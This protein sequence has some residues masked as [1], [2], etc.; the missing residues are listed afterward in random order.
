MTTETQPGAGP[1]R[2]FAALPLAFLALFLWLAATGSGTRIVR[3]P[4]GAESLGFTLSFRLDGLS[5]IFGTLISGIGVLVFIYGASYLA[6][7]RDIVRFFSWLSVF[8]VA[9]LGVVASENLIALF[10]FWELTSLSSWFLI[11]TDHERATAR[12]AALQALLV[13]G[14][15]GMAM[16][17]GFVMLGSIAGSF[18]LSAIQAQADA[19]RA[20]ALYLPILLL[21]AAGAFT[22]SAQVPFHF[23]LP[24]AME[25]PTPVSAY[26]HS[27]TMVKAGVFLLAR[28]LTVLGGTDEWIALLG[29]AG[30]ATMLTGAVLAVFAT[31]IKKILAY[32]TISALGSLVLLIGIGS[33]AA[34]QAAMV[35]LVAHAL[36][37]AALFMVGGIIDHETGTRDVERLGGLR[38]AMPFTTAAAVAGAVSLASFGPVLSFAGKEMVVLAIAGSG[39]WSLLLQAAV[40]TTSMLLAAAAALVAFRPFFGEPGEASRAHDPSPAM[41][42][43]PLLLALSGIV[44]GIVPHGVTA[45]LLAPAAAAV[46]PGASEMHVSLWHGLNVPLMMAAAATAAGVILFRTRT[47]WLRLASPLSG[48]AR[49]GPAAAWGALLRGALAFAGWQARVLQNGYLR[50]YLLFIIATLIALVAA[51]GATGGLRFRFALHDA[52][53]HEL[54]FSAIIL[55][56]ALVAVRSRSRLGSVAALGVVGYSVALL[57]ILFS[58]PDLAMTQF[59]IET[60]TVILFVLVIYRLPRY[61]R[62]TPPLGRTRDIVIC[63]LAGAVIAALV[64]AAASESAEPD[65]SS[66]YAANSVERAHGRNIVN[67]ILVDFRA[68]D[69]LGEITVLAVAAIGVLALLRLRPEG[70][71]A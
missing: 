38:Q 32:S 14:G 53:L 68:L 29:T 66:F 60:L 18:E 8:M 46:H 16:M 55:S 70:G 56:G 13:T 54:F 1:A 9:M 37:K 71:R 21:I 17:A 5:I 45:L 19:V 35:F 52:L 43:P 22:K 24:A 47:A 50:F 34:V 4:F 41:W 62:L 2:M 36:Y 3:V 33:P 27:A 31:D 39:R 11:G 61:A 58:A 48:I 20:H 42:V 69:T 57:Y 63:T 65:L 67:V 64:L 6:G 10:I 59:L 40:Y 12:E 44:F 26:L 25:A 15:G 51:A 7:R 23:W 30:A 49:F 28:L